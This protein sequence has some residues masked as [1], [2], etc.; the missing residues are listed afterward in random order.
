MIEFIIANQDSIILVLTNLLTFS[1][2]FIP[3]I[4]GDAK[5][6]KLLQGVQAAQGV[7]NVAYKSLDAFT[8]TVHSSISKVEVDNISIRETL[9]ELKHINNELKE[10]KT[11]NETLIK[12][13]K[14]L[15][16]E[17]RF[18]KNREM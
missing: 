4:V 2:M 10:T 8:S 3:K 11:Q 16:D 1:A 7:A 14:E 9:V 12:E 5:T 6:R 13:L 17:V 15:K 18:I